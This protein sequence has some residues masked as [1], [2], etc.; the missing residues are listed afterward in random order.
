MNNLRYFVVS[1]LIFQFAARDQFLDTIEKIAE[2]YILLV[3]F[4]EKSPNIFPQ[5][6]LVLTKLF[7]GL[8][9]QSQVIFDL[10]MLFF[11][12]FFHIFSVRVPVHFGV[13]LF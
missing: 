6:P 11:N 12:I 5:S 2:I 4:H 3:V 9:N 10:F 13:L 8:G 7:C 1:A